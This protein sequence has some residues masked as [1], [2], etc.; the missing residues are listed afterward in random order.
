MKSSHYVFQLGEDKNRTIWANSR[1]QAEE[2]LAGE[3]ERLAEAGYE[4]PEVEFVR[5]IPVPEL[6]W[7]KVPEV[8]S[9]D[10]YPLYR[11]HLDDD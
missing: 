3:L 4:V 7:S 9:P 8:M 6:D 10:E 1:A 2:I 5:E 11:Q